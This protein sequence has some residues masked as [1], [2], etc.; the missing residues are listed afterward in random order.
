MKIRTLLVSMIALLSADVAI[1]QNAIPDDALTSDCYDDNLTDRC[2]PEN[3]RQRRDHYNLQS[4]EELAAANVQSR[5]IFYVD[6]YGRDMPVVTFERRPGRAPHV[7][8][9]ASV[10][11]EGGE[12][13]VVEMREQ[14]TFA[15]WRDVLSQTEQFH[16]P[17]M[18]TPPP[19]TDDGQQSIRLCLHS[20]VMTM[21]ASDP[22]QQQRVR[23]ATQ[24]A[25]NEGFV[26]DP[27]F[28]LARIAYE[29]I[30]YCRA[31][32]VSR[33][34]NEVSLFSSCALLEGD[35]IAAAQALNQS[36]KIDRGVL[37]SDIAQYLDARAELNW[38]G[39]VVMGR[40][41]VASLWTTHGI[42]RRFYLDRIVGE[43]PDRV[44]ITGVLIEDYE[45]NARLADVE[46]IWTRQDD[47]DFLLLSASVQPYRSASE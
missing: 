28:D 44:R 25:C 36:M 30:P 1:A 3:Q 6:G 21:E 9:T 22:G 12:V 17:T 19:T 23:A 15:V 47:A 18:P 8:V 2:D 31:L 32:D 34:R 27:A 39:E 37:G 10:A 4:I 14:I 5:R 26:S 11:E 7:I 13:R 29:S 41:E 33:Y 24:D 16:R 46:Q 43:S 42:D 38:M 40:A 20:W 35:R 45:E